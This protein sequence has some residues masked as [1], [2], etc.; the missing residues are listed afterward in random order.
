MKTE[1]PEVIV[2]A[3]SIRKW[4][5]H[6]W[7]LWLPPVALVL[8][9]LC[10]EPL[11]AVERFAADYI[12]YCPLYDLTGLYCPGCGGTRSL[13]AL[14]HGDILLAL[15]ENPSVPALLVV[16]VLFYIE[17]IAGLFGKKI[18]LFPRNL[19]FWGICFGLIVVW[20]IFRNFMPALMPV[21]PI[22]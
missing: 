9:S 7:L 4:L 21:Q 8:G 19:L 12:F 1:I 20:D 6:Y 22:K 18:R 14:L 13:T 5:L 2:L 3:G 17:R 16:G 11:L 15:H 10:Y